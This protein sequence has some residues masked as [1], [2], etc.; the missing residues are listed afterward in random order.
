MFGSVGSLVTLTSPTVNTNA[1]SGI[2]NV[3]ATLNGT[4][5]PNGVT[6]SGWFRFSTTNPVTCDDSFGARVPS[7]GG[8]ALGSST[9]GVSFSQPV[10]GL[11][12][13]TTYYFCAIASNSLGTSVGTVVSFTTLDRPIVTTSPATRV[14]SNPSPPQ[15]RGQSERCRHH[16]MVPLR[17][18]RSGELQRH[19]R[20]PH[21][22]VERRQPRRGRIAVSYSYNTNTTG[23]S[24]GSGHDL[25]LLRHRL[26][27]LRDL[28]RRRA[29]LHHAGG[30]YRA[31]RPSAASD[32]TSTAATLNGSG[33]PGGADTTSWFRYSASNPGACSDT[34]GTRVPATGGTD[35]GAGNAN[36]ASP[37]RSPPWPRTPPTT[38]APSRSNAVGI[39]VWRARLVLT[40]ATPTVSTL[41]AT[42]VTSTTATLNGSAN[43]NTLATTGWF[44]YSTASPTTLQRHLRHPRPADRRDQPRRGDHRGA[45]RAARSPACCRGRPTTSAPSPRTR[46]GPRSASVL[47]FTT[48]VNDQAP[49]V[50]TRRGDRASPGRPATLNASANPNGQVATGWFRYATTNP[51]SCNDTFG[52]RVPATGGT[53]LGSGTSPVSYLQALTGLPSST[54]Y[55]FCALASNAAGTSVGSVLSFTTP[56]RLDRHHAGGLGDRQ[57]LGDAERLGR[58]RTATRRP[59]GSA[60]R[61]PTP[62]AATTPSARAFRRPAARRSAPGP[63]AVSYSQALTGLASNTT[64]YFCAIAQNGS[65]TSFGAVLSFVTPLAPT[66]TTVA[67][68]SVTSTSATVNGSA[69]PNG[70]ATTGW[71]RYA[72]TNPGACNDTFGTRAPATGGSDLG[73]GQQ[74]R[75]PT[76]RRSRASRSNTTYY[77]CAIAQNGVGTAFGAVLSFTTPAPPTVTTAA[78]DGD[79]RRRARR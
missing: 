2:S 20:H 25:L 6:A 37:R 77:F 51:G 62:A 57:H 3:Q 41:A 15:R 10:S 71:F 27:H 4:A 5:N 28:L 12:A 21:P 7:V 8:V 48:P 31:S 13:N 61:R 24:P 22:G 38:T 16:R 43:P 66:V 75:R 52:T 73:V 36:V 18:D 26:E 78:G 42:P 33:N 46:R 39:N 19:V 69:N 11:A 9:S 35:L 58:P 30:C 59:A 34:F 50:T 79:R 54:T 56:A 14:V 32:L 17:H 29:D 49:G 44:R 72:T 55:Y 53:A 60:T 68:S 70:G 65:G 47:S 45:L 67:A 23:V 74:R 63:P 40:P 1:A 76:R 64:Y